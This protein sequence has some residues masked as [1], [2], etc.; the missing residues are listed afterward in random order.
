MKP[1][2]RELLH[3]G[4]DLPQDVPGILRAVMETVQRNPGTWNRDNFFQDARGLALESA[5]E[6]DAGEAWADAASGCAMGWL[7]LAAR[8]NPEIF[9]CTR[10]ALLNAIPD[11][12]PH[13]DVI[14]YN[15]SLERP[16]QFV[17]WVRRA[18]YEQQPSCHHAG[19][20]CSLGHRNETY[21]V[22]EREG[23]ETTLMGGS[24]WDFCNVCDERPEPSEIARM[25][26]EIF[27]RW[28]QL[29]IIEPG[30]QAKLEEEYG[31]VESVHSW[32]ER[33]AWALAAHTT[34]PHSTPSG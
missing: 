29:G 18:C 16:E 12:F 24:A 19:W 9:E 3:D 31:G 15:D 1:T 33:M 14:R 26:R 2:I 17:E 28:G 32:E 6:S 30:E 34:Q 25:R 8:E 11:D 4:E 27:R 5:G 10:Q 21:L 22:M 13:R 20:T 23:D 7:T